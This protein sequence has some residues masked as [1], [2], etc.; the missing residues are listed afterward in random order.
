MTFYAQLDGIGD[1][2]A[3]ADCGLIYVFVC[4]NDFEVKAILQSA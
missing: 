2:F 3:L 4:F 1:E